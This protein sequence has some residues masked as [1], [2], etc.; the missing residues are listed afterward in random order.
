MN[1]QGGSSP[2][3]LKI[4]WADSGDGDALAEFR[5]SQGEWYE[6][7]T[8]EF[9]NVRAIEAVANETVFYR[10][11]LA[12]EDEL[13]V[14]CAGYHLEPLLLA[15]GTFVDSIRLHVVALA[16]DRQ[17]TKLNDGASLADALVATAADQA[18]QQL[19]HDLFTAVIAQENE[20]CLAVFERLGD[21]SQVPRDSIYLRL[22][23]RFRIAD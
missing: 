17:G 9:L 3:G 10:L 11:L 5:C 22:T 19:G 15:D 20:R 18:T 16:T 1:P 23:G 4:R 14:G 8:E 13:L 21:W 7:E 12:F 2:K 6:E